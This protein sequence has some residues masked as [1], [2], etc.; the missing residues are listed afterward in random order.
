M[1]QRGSQGPARLCV[2]FLEGRMR[3]VVP[4]GSTGNA[5]V[6]CLPYLSVAIYCIYP[7]LR[8]LNES[9]LIILRSVPARRRWSGV[10]LWKQSPGTMP[11]DF[12]R[13]TWNQYAHRLTVSFRLFQHEPHAHPAQ[14]VSVHPTPHSTPPRA[15][16]QE[17]A[18]PRLT[19][20]RRNTG[21]C[22]AAPAFVD[23]AQGLPLAPLPLQGGSSQV[24]CSPLPTQ[25]CRRGARSPAR[26]AAV[27][28]RQQPGR[29]L[30]HPCQL[31]TRCRRRALLLHP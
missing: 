11:N 16:R 28:R 27:A 15:V 19:S 30:T 7:D 29:V 21:A 1:Q 3:G 20:R 26:T 14:P 22:P 9:S 12:G 23:E 5:R 2:P 4:S 18:A 17:H 10:C 25:L 24:E 31:R 6:C 13:V 8:L